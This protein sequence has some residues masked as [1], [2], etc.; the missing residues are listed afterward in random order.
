MNTQA[1]MVWKDQL[2]RNLT[3]ASRDPVVYQCS[4]S[5]TFTHYVE[6]AKEMGASLVV[7][8]R[9]FRIMMRWSDIGEVLNPSFDGEAD[10]LEG[11]IGD[12]DGVRIRTD[13]I[14][15]QDQRI[16]WPGDYPLLA[17]I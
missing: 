13:A 15:P 6:R 12:A 9:L 5:A 7:S 11:I 1:Q 14:L 3:R 2:Q 10:L 8:P 4:D 17:L 16:S